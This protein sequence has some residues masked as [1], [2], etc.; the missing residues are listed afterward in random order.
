[1]E[2]EEDTQ[3]LPS[4]YCPEGQSVVD[5]FTQA[6]PSQY[7]PEGHD[8]EGVCEFDTQLEPFQY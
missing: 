7:W 8:V 2:E 3:A 1:M 6:F 4:Q 5:V